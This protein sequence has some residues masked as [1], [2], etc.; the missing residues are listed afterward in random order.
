MKFDEDV[1]Y[2]TR[3]EL[4]GKRYSLFDLANW[5]NGL[6]FKKIDFSDSGKPVIKIAELNNGITGTTANTKGEYFPEV[7]LT[8]GDLVFSW[9]GNPQT[10]VEQPHSD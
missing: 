4:S 2:Y 6:A 7:H 10:S 1:L 8:K 9:S 3:T 5:K